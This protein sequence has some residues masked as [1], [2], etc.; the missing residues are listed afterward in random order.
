MRTHISHISLAGYLVLAA[1]LLMAPGL[2]AADAVE[3]EHNFNFPAAS[4]SRL[5]IENLAGEI[6][7]GRSSSG[8]FEIQATVNAD[9]SAGKSATELAEM[10]EFKVSERG[11][12]V[13]FDVLYPTDDY[14]SY[15][16]NSDERWNH[17]NSTVKYLGRKVKVSSRKRRNAPQLHV[18]FVVG[19]PDGTQLR[20]RN[21]VGQIRA[22]GITADMVL[23]TASGRI[24]VEGSKGRLN[25]DTGSGS[26]KVSNHVGEVRADTGSGGITI[27]HVEGDVVADTGSGGVD[28]IDVTGSSVSADTGSGGVE[29]INVTADKI[30]ADT[31]S[32]SVQLEN[33]TGS[34]K[35]DTGSGGVTARGFFAGEVVDI[36]TGS[37]SIR[38]EGNLAQ[39]RRLRLDAGSGGVRIKT[40]QLPSLRLRVES[41]SGHIEVDLP[42]LTNVRA[43]DDYFEADVGDAEGTGDISTGSG[44]VTFRMQ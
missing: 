38:L 5:S 1:L 18:D 13:E 40:A 35:A 20:F 24:A 14:R 8:E 12:R 37:G 33:V 16:Y 44:G 27:E 26:V 10:I 25:A 34:L 3:T 43:S 23:D 42:G 36:D 7:I 31:G 30:H 15:T 2:A 28:I 19:I 11:D 4:G 21:A 29:M 17:H 22:E 41:G 9:D 6:K 32:G 39:V